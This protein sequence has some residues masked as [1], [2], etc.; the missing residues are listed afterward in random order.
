MDKTAMDTARDLTCPCGA[1]LVRDGE[2][3]KSH[4]T[5]SIC[6]E[7][8]A[9]TFRIHAAP[10]CWR[11][12]KNPGLVHDGVTHECI[13]CASETGASTRRMLQDIDDAVREGLSAWPRIM[14]R[15]EFV[16]ECIKQHRQEA[17]RRG[18]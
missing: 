9:L 18:R 14:D 12:K 2:T 16:R 4:W 17:V 5:G 11:C 10:K 6:Q 7:C 3:V 8:E 15:V 13:D 1:P